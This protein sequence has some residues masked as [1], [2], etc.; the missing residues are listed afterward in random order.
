MNDY[1]TVAVRGGRTFLDAN[2]ACIAHDGESNRYALITF[3]GGKVVSRDV[4]AASKRS[5]VEHILSREAGNGNAVY[6]DA[7]RDTKLLPL[8][9]P[10]L[11]KEADLS[12][13]RRSKSDA[14]L[15]ALAALNEKTFDKL[16]MQKSETATVFRGA[17]DNAHVKTIF[18]KNVTPHFV[19]YR[20]GLRDTLGRVS[21]LT[22]VVPKT[23]EWTDRLARVYRGL[24]DVREAVHEGVSV[25][26]LN[27]LCRRQLHHTDKLVSDV[28]VHTGFASDE[29]FRGARVLQEYDHVRIGCSVSDNEG[30]VAL[31]YTTAVPV[32]RK[33]NDENLRQVQAILDSNRQE[34]P[35]AVH[36][37]PPARAPAMRSLTRDDIMAIYRRTD[38]DSA[39]FPI[40]D[41]VVQ[42]LS[43]ELMNQGGNDY[44]HA[45]D[46]D[47]EPLRSCEAERV[48]R[49]GG[50][51]MFVKTLR[52]TE[53]DVDVV[54]GN[55]KDIRS[56]TMPLTELPPAWSPVRY[57]EAH[58]R[59]VLT[60]LERHYEKMHATPSDEYSCPT[61]YHL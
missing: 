56:E 23:E 12:L 24:H 47:R 17:A 42:M 40:S 36:P 60:A 41:E 18:L 21:D 13:Y 53:A 14:E 22:R 28:V 39:N 55:L 9:A 57:G 6:V 10:P 58:E 25:D 30:N 49:K 59:A 3:R 38:A 54:S 45:T 43:R 26:D 46:C 19:Q 50:D 5:E 11:S 51:S 29:T 31:V 1:S 32:Y 37:P 16:H 33:A 61:K 20:A 48:Y 4:Y 35:P 2:Y 44:R 8:Q 7:R 27:A 15:R 52:G 34:P